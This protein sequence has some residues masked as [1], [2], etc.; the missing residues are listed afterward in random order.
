MYS[1]V[2]YVVAVLLL[3]STITL[4]IMLSIANDKIDRLDSQNISLLKDNNKLVNTN[5]ELNIK[6]ANQNEAIKTL[7][8]VSLR[9]KQEYSKSYYLLA[10]EY[11][12]KVE[13]YKNMLLQDDSCE[14]QL[15]LIQEAQE[16]F[17]Q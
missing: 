13:N 10:S 7:E 2:A 14:A 4:S 9:A 12:K 5:A 17:L 3:I 8:N 16:E 11:D 6:L 1:W 15:L